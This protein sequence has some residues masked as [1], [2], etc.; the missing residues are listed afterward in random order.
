MQRIAIIDIGSNSARLVISHIFKNGAYKMF[1]NQKESL[2]LGQ[3]VDGSNNLTEE[4][5]TSLIET[6]N[7]Y[8]YMCKIYKVNKII[9]VATAAIRN[10]GN[11]KEVVAKVLEKTG[12]ELKIISGEEEAYLSY[13][14]VI[15]TLNVNSGIIFDLGGGSTELIFFKNRK[16]VEAVSLPIGAVNTTD[17]FNTKDSMSPAV[18]ETVRLFIKS[19]LEQY[20]WLKQNALPLISVGGTGRAVAKII[21]RAK[22][23]P[24]TKLHNYTYSL[25][26]YKDF[27]D[28]MIVTNLEQR[29]KISGLGSERK[30]IILAGICIIKE[31]FE[32]TGSKKMVTSGCGLREG[33]FFNYYT[34]TNNLPTI[35]PDILK[36]ST[37]NML[38][39][40]EPDKAHVRH[41]TKLAL[42]MFDSWKSI[43]G[44]RSSYRRLLET[45][46]LLHDIGIGINY[47]SHARHSAYVIQNAKLFG[48]SHKE[49]FMVSV[50]AGWHH[51]H[52]KNYFRDPFYKKML[53]ESNWKVVTKLAVLLA[54]AESLDFTNSKQIQNITPDIQKKNASLVINSPGLPSIELHELYE[55]KSWFKKTMGV[56][57][58]VE[59]QNTIPADIQ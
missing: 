55:H 6:I 7:N 16:L 46:A 58:N 45:A 28:R 11:G 12:I 24:A 13:L 38:N 14:G 48:L 2:R 41:V 3:K 40:Y 50:I 15:N 43:H 52:S 39:I 20:Q 27:F 57:L 36:E 32:A 37:E 5:E 33:L 51:G 23:Y 47:Y 1:F 34:Q 9:A 29:K 49:Q 4:A 31:L 21:Q 18:Y 42:T 22:K 53:T 10:S 25:D 35:I 56:E 30:D 19:K 26:T 59:V 44:L 54:L 17:I 8:A